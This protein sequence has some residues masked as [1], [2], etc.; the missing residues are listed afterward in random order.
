MSSTL[1]NGAGVPR[2]GRDES[3]ANRKPAPVTW[4]KSSASGAVDCV[5]VAASAEDQVLLRTSKRPDGVVLCLSR[6]AFRTFV[7]E[8]RQGA[9]DG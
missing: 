2:Q 1:A 5:E 6:A 8:V 4:R 3:V 7:E 9:L